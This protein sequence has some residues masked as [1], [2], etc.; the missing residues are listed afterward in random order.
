MDIWLAAEQSG[1]GHGE[2]LRE[3]RRLRWIA[4]TLAPLRDTIPAADLERLERA[5]CLVI[6]GE[7]LIVLR[8]VCHLSDDEAVAVTHWAAEALIAAGL[9]R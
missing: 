8:D 1:S 6:G 3:G 4:T 7:A 2:E 9:S 5:L